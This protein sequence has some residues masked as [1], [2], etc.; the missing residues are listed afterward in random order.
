MNNFY[1][2]IHTADIGF[3]LYFTRT[4]FLVV[5]I[6]YSMYKILNIHKLPIIRIVFSALLFAYI[7]SVVKF[8]LSTLWSILVLFILFISF[9]SLFFKK[10]LSSSITL[11]LLSLSINYLFLIIGIV[12]NYLFNAVIR[13]SNDFVN[14]SLLIFIHGILAYRFFKIER[15]K[16][17]FSFFTD[18]NL[19]YSDFLDLFV[20][21]TSSIF[22]FIYILVTSSDIMPTNILLIICIFVSVIMFVT[23]KRSITLYYKHKLL[24][25]EL[26]ETK[27]E[28]DKKK[29]EV[30]E[31][32]KE[33][34]EFIKTSHSIAHKQKVLEYKLNQLSPNAEVASELDL[35]N[36]LSQLKHKLDEQQSSPLSSVDKTEIPVIDDMLQFF[37]SECQRTKI[38]FDVKV[39]GNIYYMTNHLIS[40][41]SLQIL[42]A[43]HIK[44][45][46]IAIQHSD[47][48]NRSIL[49]KLGLIDDIYCLYVYDSG[50]EFDKETL[51]SL[52]SKP[53]T[54]HEE[55]SGT[56][57]G[58]MNTFDTL[59]KYSASLR[60]EEIGP[61][62]SDN[63]TKVIKIQFNK[64][65]HLEIKSYRAEELRKL[66]IPSKFTI[67]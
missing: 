3:L 10:S 44:D 17:G 38:D 52:G 16:N 9:S 60:I 21:N 2:M 27:A 23:I 45:A 67:L 62:C 33:N 15:F 31:L 28:L 18:S 56:G 61:A 25:R 26:T 65:N 24:V 58:F 22:I 63:Y 29:K 40:I 8:S 35:T 30:E 37:Q 55:D 7:S 11:A 41:D 53:I 36:D 54:T 6:F 13:F 34:L 39:L 4:L 42:L 57:L 20:L 48:I 43:D 49:V 64:L 46:M 32:E 5:F 47:N 66:D 12:I 50:I 59:N 19:E 14:L 1:L 51:L